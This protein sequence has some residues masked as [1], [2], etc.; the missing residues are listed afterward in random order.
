M[1]R[2][3]EIVLAMEEDMR[4]IQVVIQE[5]DDATA[6]PPKQL[7]TFA[8]PEADLASLRPETALDDLEATTHQTGNAILRRRLQAQWDVV[9]AALAEHYRQRLFPPAR[10]SRRPGRRKGR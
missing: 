2:W 3:A 7:A 1:V 5:V 8:L 6:D 4:R 9:D 10:P